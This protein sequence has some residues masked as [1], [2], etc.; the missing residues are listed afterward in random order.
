LFCVTRIGA[1]LICGVG[2]H[3]EPNRDMTPGFADYMALRERVVMGT[4]VAAAWVFALAIPPALSGVMSAPDAKVWALL[5]V[6]YAYMTYSGI[7][8]LRKRWRS[9]F[10]LRVVIP[11]CLLSVSTV[12]AISGVWA[13]ILHLSEWVERP[14]VSA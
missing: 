2:R 13:K 8:A 3:M 5:A 7:R 14:V 1:L 11:A 9:R 12:L 4:F 6:L 10:I